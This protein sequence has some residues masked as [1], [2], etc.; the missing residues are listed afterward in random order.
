[1]AILKQCFN[2]NLQLADP[3]GTLIDVSEERD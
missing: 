3:D 2:G 1:L